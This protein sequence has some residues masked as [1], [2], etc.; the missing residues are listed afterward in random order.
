MTS[1][2]I[3]SSMRIVNS[4]W[5][6][7]LQC[8]KEIALQ[9]AIGNDLQVERNRQLKRSVDLQEEAFI[10]QNKANKAYSEIVDSLLNDGK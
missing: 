10:S 2:E 9:L 1:E 7:I 6:P 8:L 4:E 5:T 3:K